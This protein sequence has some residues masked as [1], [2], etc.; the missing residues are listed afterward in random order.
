MIALSWFAL[1]SLALPLFACPALGEATVAG[2]AAATGQLGGDPGWREDRIWYDG[3]AEKAVYRAQRTIYGISRS[4]R[5]TAYTNKQRMDPERTVKASGADGVE[6]FKHHWS[7][8]IPTENYDY[9]FSTALFLRTEDLGFFKLTVGTQEDCGTSF[10]QVWRAQGQL[11]WLESVYFPG[12]GISEGTL[13][14]GARFFDELPLL[15]RDFPFDAPRTIELPLVGSQKSSRSVAFETA[16]HTVELVG[17]E[18][19]KLPIGERLAH[20]LALKDADGRTVARFWF[21]SDP[22]LRHLLLAYEDPQ[23]TSYELESVER[24]AYWERPAR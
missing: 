10:K 13:S 12:G 14:R 23:G 1:G 22:E 21:A 16:K 2:T 6:V 18:K 9:D 15:L 3:K 5:A 11:S 20:E 8:R 17:T 7:E 24:T 19:V 4:Y